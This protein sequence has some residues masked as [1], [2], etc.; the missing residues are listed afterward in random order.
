MSLMTTATLLT[1]LLLGAGWAVYALAAK[2]ETNKILERI[3]IFGIFI[4]PFIPLIVTPS[5]FFPFITGKNFL[6]RLVVEIITAAWIILAIRAPEF[7]PKKSSVFWAFAAL[8][9]TMLVSVFVGADPF[10]SFWSN[11]ERMEGYVTLIHFFAFFLVTASVISFR[12]VWDKLLKVMLGVSVYISLYGV[13][14]LLG[15]LAI[16]QSGTRLDGT[17]GNADYLAIFAI[18]AIFFAAI[19]AVREK[20]E[21]ISLQTMWWSIGVIGFALLLFLLT[22]T[23]ATIPSVLVA[24]L[25][26]T[27]IAALGIASVA[28]AKKYTIAWIYA[29]IALLNLVILYYTA[30]RGAILGLIAG[31]ILMALIIL[32][33]RKGTKAVRRSALWFLIAVA[34]GAGGFVAL[35]SSSFVENSP[36]LSRFASINLSDSETTA[37]FYIWDMAWQGFLEKPIFGWG[38]ENFNLVFN[39]FYAPQIYSQEQWFDRTHDIFF[40]WLVTGG[41]VGCAA[42]FFLFGAALWMVWKKTEISFTEKTLF[43][44]LFAAYLVNN[45]FVFDNVTSLILYVTVLAYIQSMSMRAAAKKETFVAASATAT[46][47]AVPIVIVIFAAIIYFLNFPGYET[48]VALINALTALN[49]NDATSSIAY[50]EKAAS[51]DALGREE[52]SEQIV[53]STQTILNSGADTDTKQ[54]F[55]SFAQGIVARQLAQTPTDAREW[56]FAGNFYTTVGENS[57]AESA[58]KQAQALSPNKQTILFSLG[59]LYLTENNYVQAFAV[60]KQAYELDTADTDAL[61]W[62]IAAAIYDGQKQLAASLSASTTPDVALSDTV[63]GAY[64]NTSDWAD[65]ATL[66]QNRIKYLPDNVQNHLSLV[67][68]YVKLGENSAAIAEIKNIIALYPSYT[69]VGE[70]AISDIEAGKPLQ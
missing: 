52:V 19:I 47:V 21:K 20:E 41:I 42:Y 10:R 54:Q 5:L 3:I 24:A 68:T 58:Y 16:N 66:F 11:F 12:N 2:G 6:F 13:F 63:A 43:T 65:L 29:A 9:A 51:Y 40:D 44:G 27:L 49:Q 34:L 39:K 7:R 56:L 32:L 23:Q 8:M 64:L 25:V 62:Y 28:L 36:V 14:Q 67:A 26:G 22:L 45:I 46:R 53:E 37:R 70:Q 15:F 17:F 57:Q 59:S 50:F 48:S 30:T 60:F 61:E 31:I 38:Q 35:K 18:F 69:S 4:T 55:A 33:A 1:L